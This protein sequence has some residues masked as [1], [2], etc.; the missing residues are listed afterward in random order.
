MSS[1]VFSLL[2]FFSVPPSMFTLLASFSSHLLILFSESDV[3]EKQLGIFPLGKSLAHKQ[4]E[5][6]VSIPNTYLKK[7]WRKLK[8]KSNRKTFSSKDKIDPAVIE[9]CWTEGHV[10]GLSQDLRKISMQS[11]PGALFIL[12]TGQ[13]QGEASSQETGSA[14][15]GH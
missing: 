4:I 6:S 2:N 1:Q 8:K 3:C 11:L 13:G 10:Y 15:G 5:L 12:W 14:V 9:K 7:W